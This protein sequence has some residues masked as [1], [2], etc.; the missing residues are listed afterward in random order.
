DTSSHARHPPVAP[1]QPSASTARSHGPSPVGYV[2]LPLA[3]AMH[4]GTTDDHR[5]GDGWSFPV[6][7]DLA[8][9]RLV[10]HGPSARTPHHARRPTARGRGRMGAYDPT[11]AEGLDA[12]FPAIPAAQR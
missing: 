3:R 1:L 10:S 11:M 4:F 6:G 9:R 5:T 8:D 2:P 12:L 7:G